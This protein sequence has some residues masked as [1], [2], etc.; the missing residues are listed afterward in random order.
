LPKMKRFFT[1]LT[2]L[3]AVVSLVV[4][5]V[6]RVYSADCSKVEDLFSSTYDVTFSLQSN[7]DAAVTQKISLKNL[8][9]DCFVSEFGLTVNSDR[10]QSVSGKDSLGTIKTSS[11]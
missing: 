9:S 7:G 3:F 4:L 10:V 11:K 8:S 5:P 6:A 2:F 1:L